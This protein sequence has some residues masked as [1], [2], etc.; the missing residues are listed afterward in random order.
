MFEDYSDEPIYN[1]KAVATQSGVEASTLRAWERRY[2]VPQPPRSDSGYRLY[3]ARDTAII[4]WLKQ[5]IESGM[6]ISQAVSMLRSIQAGRQTPQHHS[7][8]HH[9]HTYHNNGIQ[10]LDDLLPHSNGTVKHL[11]QFDRYVSVAFNCALAFDEAG[12][13]HVLSDAFALY[14]V[15]DVCARVIQP[16]QVMMGDGWHKGTVT[17]SAEHFASNLVRRKLI[18]LM[19]ACPPPTDH[20][21]IVT[22][23]APEEFHEIGMLMLSLYLR[24]RG[25]DVIF[26]G[27]AIASNRLGEML[28]QTEPRLVLMS[29]STLRT[30]ANLMDIVDVLS[31]RR[32]AP[33]LFAYGGPIFQRLPAL[34]KRLSGIH[35]SE[36]VSQAIDQID[37]MLNAGES[38]VQRGGRASTEAKQALNDFR[39]SRALLAADMMAGMRQQP[40]F[41][42]DHVALSSEYFANA[43][44]SVLRL[45]APELLAHPI[46]WQ[47]QP[48]PPDGPSVL[49]LQQHLGILAQAVQQR[50]PLLSRHIVS[51]CVA[52]LI[53]SVRLNKG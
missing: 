42:Y 1:V 12:F 26:L 10:P 2:G 18:A 53:D 7:N 13:E 33:V 3:S 48:R 40:A 8:P 27:Q 21:K 6:N 19:A 44:E 43:I 38:F 51:Q 32:L 45:D 36:D 23:C 31:D 16:L 5:Q 49:Q 17:I 9:G 34:A 47:W 28:L 46:A 20:R 39:L 52:Y 41:N 4:R 15:E 29:A 22:G 30:A 11:E 35:I 37:A 50:V 24:R 25:K 14:S